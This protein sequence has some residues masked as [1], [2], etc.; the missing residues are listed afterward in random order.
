MKRAVIAA[1]LLL[2]GCALAPSNDE[3][4]FYEQSYALPLE[5]RE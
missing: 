4:P 1:T 5:A 3:L 2:A